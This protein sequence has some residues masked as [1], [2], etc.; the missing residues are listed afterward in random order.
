MPFKMRCPK[1]NGSRIA[2]GSTV[3]SCETI[4]LLW[5]NRY[6]TTTIAGT[7]ICS[8]SHTKRSYVL[9]RG[10]FSSWAAGCA[11]WRGWY[12]DAW[13][14]SDGFGG[15]RRV[16]SGCIW[17]SWRMSST[18]LE[19]LSNSTSMFPGKSLMGVDWFIV[20]NAYTHTIHI[21]LEIFTHLGCPFLYCFVG[22]SHNQVTK[23]SSALYPLFTSTLQS[24]IVILPFCSFATDWGQCCVGNDW[25]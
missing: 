7:F 1:E 3:W 12:T 8:T 23:L 16:S 5:V 4:E 14:A 13:I 20:I 9:S 24:R 17:S 11:G 25:V 6:S 2:V 22:S 18:I 19:S 15:G 21:F 10:A